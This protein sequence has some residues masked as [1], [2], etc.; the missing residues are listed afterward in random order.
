[1]KIQNVLLLLTLSLV[2]V[3]AGPSDCGKAWDRVCAG[4][5]TV[6]AT[7][8][9]AVEDADKGFARARAV[10]E[11][12]DCPPSLTFDEA[13]TEARKGLAWAKA[14]LSEAQRFQ[15]RADAAVLACKAGGASTLVAGETGDQLKRAKRELR[16]L[17]R[18]VKRH[19]G[20]SR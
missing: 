17:E 7:I 10:W 5:E 19:Q 13:C 4:L 20:G 1:M 8:R 18:W 6:A 15:V 14:R 9:D 16:D 2:L 3:A 12:A 11:A